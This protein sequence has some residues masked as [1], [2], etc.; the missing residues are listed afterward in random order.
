MNLEMPDRPEK[1]DEQQKGPRKIWSWTTFLFL[2]LS[3]LLAQVLI[4]QFLTPERISWSDFRQFYGQEDVEH[5]VV[6]NNEL[7]EIYIRESSLNKEPFADLKN[8]AGP[9]FIFTI[10]SVESLERKLSEAKEAFGFEE[11]LDIIYE[12]RTDWFSALLAWMLPVLLIIG[13]FYLMSRRIKSPG[14]INPFDFVK[15]KA[16]IFDTTNI[17]QPKFA[18][19]AG[20]ESAKVEVME[21]VDFLKNPSFYTRL[22]AKIPKG[23]ILVGPPGTGKTLMARAVAGEAKVPFFSISGSEFVEMFV[24]VGASRVR[25]L[26]QKAKE[27]APSIIFIDEIDAVGRSRGSA[28]SLQSND[29][30]E[31]TLN[32]LL[33]E[34]DG[35]G[36]N[37]GVIVMAA[38][39]RPDI[40]DKALLRPGRFDRHI[41]LELPNISEREAIFKVHTR[42]LVLS[43]D[44]N[45]AQLAAMTPGFSG[46]DIANICNE[47]ALIAARKTREQIEQE[48]FYEA[49]DRIIGGLERKGKIISEKEK[50][51]IAYHEAGHA[52][53]SWFEK[54]AEE[55]MKVTIVPRGKSLGAA[56]YQ[57]EEHAILTKSQLMASLVVA[58][59]GRAAEKLIFNEVSSGAL[60]D[61]EKATKQAYTMVAYYGIS[62]KV[63]N[64]SFYDSSGRTEQSLHKPYSESTG[65]LIDSEVK[66]FIELAFA[67]AMKILESHRDQLEILAQELLEKEVIDKNNLIEILGKRAGTNTSVAQVPPGIE[68]INLT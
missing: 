23:V 25:D 24:G 22:G 13:L 48:D 33:T 31:S 7:A 12:K 5:L 38:T 28:F 35:F 37:V 10:G 68:K 39:N 64:I 41:Y 45:L 63:G 30:R 59:G 1:S 14:D 16:K 11:E 56:W 36:E 8:P 50:E 66:E 57:P 52:V 55:L 27:K 60:D 3:Y 65:R 62:D 61:L 15:S 20:H 46:A 26:F 2:I 58:L 40:L 32:Q 29:E 67:K 34:M 54:E 44:L 4:N 17:K 53:V 18:D 47:A 51:R 43:P 9:H 21:I 49:I 42:Q 6:V 19:V